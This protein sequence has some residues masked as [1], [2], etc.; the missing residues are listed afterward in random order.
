MNKFKEIVSFI[1]K[2]LK[3]LISKLS[4]NKIVINKNKKTKIID[5]EGTN[6]NIFIKRNDECEISQ[7]SFIKK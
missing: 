2:G 1:S 3:L 5:N 6:V 7:N 4:Y